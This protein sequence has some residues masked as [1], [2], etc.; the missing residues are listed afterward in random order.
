MK[1]KDF[2]PFFCILIASQFSHGA[3]VTITN[4][5]FSTLNGWSTTGAGS[6]W[7]YGGQARVNTSLGQYSYLSQTIEQTLQ[8]STKYTLIFTVTSADS[9]SVGLPQNFGA[10]ILAGNETQAWTS[11]SNPSPTTNGT[12]WS[13]SFITGNSS[14]GLGQ[15]LKIQ[16]YAQGSGY[17]PN[18][19]GS[20]SVYFSNVQLDASSFSTNTYS[21]AWVVPMDVTSV[22]FDVTGASGGN[23]FGSRYGVYGGCGANVK[24]KLDVTP[25]STLYLFIG[26]AGSN[27]SQ[28]FVLGGFNGGGDGLKNV[29][30][31]GGGASDIR[32][33][34]TSLADRIV[35]AGGGGGANSYGGY[36][37]SGGGNGNNG[38]LGIGSS[39]NFGGG[40]GFY[41]GNIDA[42]NGRGGSNYYNQ[43]LCSN[44]TVTSGQAGNATMNSMN[45]SIVLTYTPIPILT[46]KNLHFSSVANTGNSSDSLDYDKD[47]IPNLIEYAVGG[48]PKV[49]DSTTVS[50]TLVRTGDNLQFSFTCND[51]K[52]DISYIVES[53]SNLSQW[54][55]TEIASNV[56]GQKTNPIGN[57]CTVSD[58][59]SGSRTVTVSVSASEK[60]FVRLKILHP[61]P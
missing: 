1:P 52:T 22:N 50:P 57:L 36:G 45:G 13:L 20:Q 54:S 32:I 43:T 3:S 10:T 5:S 34:G 49:V 30:G 40:G 26:G 19:V 48:N 53:S 38:I 6:W 2:I 18:G 41:G 4:P 16:L 61:N 39:G 7:S 11:I 12:Q 31:A 44:V 46:W 33:G 51:T 25:G 29:G 37:G 24:G 35:V 14:T 47:G 15:Q 9:L 42:Y 55:W 23:S 17:L 8:P 27:D 59:G 28:A 21:E 60:M 58:T 56:G